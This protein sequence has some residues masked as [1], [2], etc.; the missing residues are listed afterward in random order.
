MNKNKN[1]V[2]AIIQARLNSSRFPAKV[3]KKILNKTILE[4][5]H[6]R[7]SKSKYNLKIV[8]AIPKNK[9]NT[10]LKFFFKI[11]KTYIF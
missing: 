6:R 7:L 2:T 5:I 1:N 8:F 4:I 9:K 10:K 3:L 11:K